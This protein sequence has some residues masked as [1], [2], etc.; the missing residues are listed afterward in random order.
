MPDAFDTSAGVSTAF[1]VLL[2]DLNRT[3]ARQ[4][5]TRASGR[6]LS[7]KPRHHASRSPTQEAS[8]LVLSL[9]YAT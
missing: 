1:E 4:E 8:D 7:I 3:L 9:A 6:S 5:T 2:V